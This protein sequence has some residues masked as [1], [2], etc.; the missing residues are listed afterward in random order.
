MV[1][2]SGEMF[3]I[4]NTVS[5]T[6]A[7]KRKMV[8][9]RELQDDEQL[10]KAV[11]DNVGVHT[12]MADAIERLRLLDDNCPDYILDRM[13]LEEANTKILQ[14]LKQSN[15]ASGVLACTSTVTAVSANDD[16]KSGF[17]SDSDDIM[18]Y[19]ETLHDLL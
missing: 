16:N 1:T 17:Y 19:D 7:K 5:S 9:K 4:R 15:C 14:E 3:Y 11:R 13:C 2:L 18:L 6:K 10:H 8:A 12:I